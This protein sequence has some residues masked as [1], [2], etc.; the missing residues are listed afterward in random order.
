M[1]IYEKSLQALLS[2][3]P[4]GFAARSGVLARLAS[5]AQTGELARKL[6]IVGLLQHSLRTDDV[7][8][9]VASLRKYVCG[10]QARWYMTRTGLTVNHMNKI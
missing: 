7:F 6:E 1:K 8:P 3:A 2:A 5:L 10:S 4:R 9:V